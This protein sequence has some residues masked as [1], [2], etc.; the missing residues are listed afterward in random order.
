MSDTRSRPV[1]LVPRVLPR[2][3]HKL[4][5]SLVVASQRQ[6]LLEAI[7]ELVAEKGYAAVTLND[8]VRR[9]AIA[10]RTFYVHFP[11]KLGCFIAAFD[12]FTLKL[13]ETVMRLF[14]MQGSV[15]ARTQ[16]TV[17]GL[18]AA[19]AAMPEATRAF[20]LELPAAGAEALDRRLAMQRE[21]ARLL[22]QL[23]REVHDGRPE[24]RELSEL[25]A[26]AAV[27]ALHELVVRTVHEHGPSQL[28]EVGRELAPL[29]AAF[30][31]LQVPDEPG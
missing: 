30:I 24:V 2:G 19:L 17:R 11:D 21:F 8:I 26:L 23:S 6:R 20:Y 13:V 1:E 15:H 29:A 7:T 22:I 3:R 9:A 5:H 25:H 14:R 16:F 31:T 27:G 12:A 18:L 10:K 4:K 28:L